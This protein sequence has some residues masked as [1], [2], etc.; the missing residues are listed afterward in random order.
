MSESIQNKLISINKAHYY[1]YH[2][3][4]IT[5]YSVLAIIFGFIHLL[6]LYLIGI[7]IYQSTSLQEL[8]STILM[9]AFSLFVG[10]IPLAITCLPYIVL[11]SY[12]HYKKP[13]RLISNGLFHNI[14]NL[15]DIE[16]ERIIRIYQHKE[17][18]LIVYVS[19]DLKRILK[20][21]I[22][23]NFFESPDEIIE[24]SDISSINMQDLELLKRKYPDIQDLE[25]TIKA[26]SHP[27]DSFINVF[28]EIVIFVILLAFSLLVHL[29]PF[30]VTGYLLKYVFGC[31]KGR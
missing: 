6:I 11:K 1:F 29:W 26:L 19:T 14:K 31:L 15:E 18:F 20:E 22:E 12:L 10:I 8:I 27:P 21:K 2:A 24:D 28:G 30:L 9:T 17:Y 3:Q 13:E 23:L 5:A 7:S 4:V 16:L 25:K